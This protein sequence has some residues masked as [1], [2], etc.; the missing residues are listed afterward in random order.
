MAQGPRSVHLKAKEE[1]F[2]EFMQQ[3]LRNSPMDRGTGPA[4]VEILAPAHLGA[5]GRLEQAV[6][7][8]TL[9]NRQWSRES[10]VYFRVRAIAEAMKDSRG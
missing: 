2:G 8:L 6:E 1:T 10:V 4:S 5:I 9:A 7:H 3:P